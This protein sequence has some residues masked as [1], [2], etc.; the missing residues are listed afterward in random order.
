MKLFG[1]D[2]NAIVQDEHRR[3]TREAPMATPAPPEVTKPTPKQRAPRG[4]RMGGVRRHPPAAVGDRF[5][6]YTVVA[7]V[8]RGARSDER[9]MVVCSQC[10]SRRKAYVFNLRK[11]SERP[12]RLTE[13]CHCNGR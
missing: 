13:R 12:L 10:G 7:L 5:G 3:Q 11:V 9:V 6:P 8:P 1:Y 2:P 4:M